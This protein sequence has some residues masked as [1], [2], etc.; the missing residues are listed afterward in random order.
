MQ[1]AEHDLASGAI[2]SLGEGDDTL[3]AWTPDEFDH[4]TGLG[5]LRHGLA[6]TDE[7]FD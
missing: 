4:F 1:P 5:L 7:R 3:E 2:L 6:A